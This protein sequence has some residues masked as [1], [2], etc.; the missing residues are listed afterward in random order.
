[1]EGVTYYNHLYIPT[2]AIRT[3]V[4]ITSD[5]EPLDQCQ[6]SEVSSFY[7][8]SLLRIIVTVTFYLDKDNCRL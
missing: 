6:E 2:N 3:S 4:I 8:C 7:R 1:M 5:R